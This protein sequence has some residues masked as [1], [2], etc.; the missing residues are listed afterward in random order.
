MTALPIIETQSGDVSAHIPTNVISITDGQIYLEPD[1]FFAGVR[2][3]I[4]VGI[5]V[6][7]VGGNA[8]IKAM[9]SV[10]GKLKLEMAQYRDVAAFSQ[11]ASDLDRSTQLQLIRGQR[12]TELLKQ[13]LASPMNV[14]DQVISI[15]AGGTGVLDAITNQQVKAFEI[16]VLAHVKD[17]YPEVAETIRTT[18]AV[19]KDIEETLRKAVLEFA[20][21]AFKGQYA[22]MATLKEIRARIKAAKNI[23]QIT[24][25][26]KLVAAARL[27][28]ATD[29][30]LRLDPTPT[31]CAASCSP[32]LLPATCLPPAY[33]RA[34]DQEVPCI[35]LLTSDRGLAGAYNSGLIR[36]TVEFMKEQPGQG[37]LITVG[38]KGTQFFGKR[39]YTLLHSMTVP[40]SGAYP[41]GRRRR[42]ASRAPDL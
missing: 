37:S 29:R 13:D 30:V 14:V 36:K 16:G 9:K 1:L 41:F 28:K 4:N 15:F 26:M 27:K 19:S 32:S 6:S 40:T 35:V 2:P 12:L 20:A 10:A 31:T 11:F 17:K 22:S 3:A 8:Q 5:S 34:G 21:G 23:Q 25:A 18:K 7:R 39:G 24:K 33:G 42:D 38:K